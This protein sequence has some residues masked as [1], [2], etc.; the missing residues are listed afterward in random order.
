MTVVSPFTREI[1]EINRVEC[2]DEPFFN[3]DTYD[4]F[5]LKT[6]LIP[7]REKIFPKGSNLD[8]KLIRHNDK[9]RVNIIPSING[10][11][12]II[13]EE[14]RNQFQI[15]LDT[16]VDLPNLHCLLFYHNVKI[17]SSSGKLIPIS[18]IKEMTKYVNIPQQYSPYIQDGD[19]YIDLSDELTQYMHINEKLN[20]D[21]AA[22]L[23]IKYDSGYIVNAD[24]IEK[25]W[26]LTNLGNGLF[27]ADW[28]NE[29]FAPNIVDFLM[30]RL[31]GK[32]NIK[33]YVTENR[34]IKHN[35]SKL[36][37]QINLAGIFGRDILNIE[38]EDYNTAMLLSTLCMK[39]LG[40]EGKVLTIFC[41]RESYLKLY[42]FI[43]A[44]IWK[45]YECD[46]ISYIQHTD[47][48]QHVF[49]CKVGFHT[50]LD[51]YTR[52][53]KRRGI[54]LLGALIEK[55]GSNDIHTEIEKSDF[56]IVDIL[57]V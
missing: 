7:F 20:S 5:C 25:S 35:I 9:L 15:E 4:L 29:R 32:K 53:F 56:N 43:S 31:G 47:T 19:I 44:N 50:N 42:A 48:K 28:S 46:C 14:I 55:T 22:E 26:N 38:V 52:E 40:T 3:H 23:K 12:V 17:F 27:K 18:W 1:R 13:N 49:S 34:V 21:I 8:Y 51:F 24:K 36:L 45:N 11:K 30:E 57:G 6:R 2:T 16:L 37:I 41:T 54:R 39:M 33:I 10:D